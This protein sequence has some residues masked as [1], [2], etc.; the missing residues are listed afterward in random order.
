M[1]CEIEEKVASQGFNSAVLTL[2]SFQSSQKVEMEMENSPN[3][4]S[5]ESK[6]LV[7][8]NGQVSSSRR[9]RSQTGVVRKEIPK[10]TL[11]FISKKSRVYGKN[12]VKKSKKRKRLKNV[13][14]GVAAN[15][16][17]RKVYD[18]EEKENRLSQ[19]LVVLFIFFIVN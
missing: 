17:R 3:L 2:L 5:P 18:V 4:N 1:S 19:D 16:K 15:P 11:N 8:K 9:T 14:V 7:V 6:S 10:K 12:Y 13:D